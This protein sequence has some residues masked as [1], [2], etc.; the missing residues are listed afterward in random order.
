MNVCSIC[1]KQIERE[2]A[3]VL[4]ISGYGNPR[5]ICD[6][7]EQQMDVAMA[8]RDVEEIEATIKVLGDKMNAS[9]DDYAVAA[10]YN[11]IS[12]ACDRLVKIKEGTYDFSADEKMK[13][14]EEEASFD[15]IPEELQ[16]TEEDRELDKRDAEKQK[17]FDEIMNWVSLIA[18]GGTAIY[19]ILS[20]L[21]R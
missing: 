18:I 21:L 4:T 5:Y 14:L 11:F 1:G 8:S 2:D 19:V 6:E 10:M 20:Y 3:P 15:E 16:E 13:E 12:V 17:K 7:C 9:K